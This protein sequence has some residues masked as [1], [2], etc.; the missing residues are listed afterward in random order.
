MRSTFKILFYLK[1]SNL[2]PDGKVP[3]M[4]RITVN[5]TVAQFSCKFDIDPRLWD[6]KANRAA[7]KSLEAQKINGKLDNI[8]VQINKHYQRISD[9]DAYVSAAKVRNAYFG[10]DEGYKS[11]LSLFQERNESFAKRV[12]VDRSQSLLRTYRC[13]EAK[14]AGFIKAKYH[15]NDIPLKELEPQFIEDFAIYLMVDCGMASSTANIYMRPVKGMITK[16]HNRG[17]IA[18]NPFADY[19]LEMEVRERG[20]LNDAQ[21]KRFMTQKLEVPA[22][23]FVR[24]MFVFCCFTGLSCIDLKNLT[25]DNLKTM[26]DGSRWIITKRQKT[27]V[28]TDV[29]LL[30]VP[31]RLIE[32]YSAVR[33][34]GNKVFKLLDPGYSNVLLKEIARQCGFDFNLSFHMSRHTFATTVTLSQRVPLETVSKMLGHTSIRTTQIYAKITNEK[35]G[36]DMEDLAAKI[37]NKYAII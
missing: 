3:V 33:T 5:G 30:D 35:I 21:L 14:L 1:N 4:G 16:A 36:R 22:Q 17:W 10:F 19:H 24:D 8:R 2:Q 37:G 29:R 34:E 18:R 27:K 25:H 28:Q 23:S 32:K 31:L 11:L 9:A 13:A 6:M 7:G 26:A 12:K 20:F 15:V